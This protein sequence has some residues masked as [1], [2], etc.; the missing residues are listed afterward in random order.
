LQEK[1]QTKEKAKKSSNSK[2]PLKQTFPNTLYASSPPSGRIYHVSSLNHL[3]NKRVL[4]T[5]CT[6]SPLLAM[7]SPNTN[8]EKHEIV[9]VSYVAPQ[10]HEIINVALHRKYS[11]GIIFI[12]FQERKDL[13]HG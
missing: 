1:W 2:L 5:L 9:D 13:Y 10:A 6:F 3:V 12:F 11:P 8:R 7:D 4:P